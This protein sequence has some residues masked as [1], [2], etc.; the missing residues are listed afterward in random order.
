MM[1]EISKYSDSVMNCY[2]VTREDSYAA[3]GRSCVNHKF[4]SVC[5]HGV[6]RP[7]YAVHGE[8]NGH[9]VFVECNHYQQAK[10]LFLALK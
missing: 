5:S 1:Y 7:L 9:G 3:M 8:C 6:Q 4:Q 10:A 2:G